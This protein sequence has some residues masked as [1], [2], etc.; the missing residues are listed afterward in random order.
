MVVPPPAPPAGSRR[1]REPGWDA[2]RIGFVLLVVLYHATHLG[3]VLHPDLAPRPVS[4][5][6]QIGASLLLVVSAYFACATLGRQPAGRYWWGRVARLLPAFL[7]AVPVAWI[8]LRFLA[9]DDWGGPRIRELAWNWLMLGNWDVVRFP[10]LD[11][12]F[13]TLPLQLMAFT[14]AAVLGTTRWASGARVRILTWALVLVPLLQW[15]L[16]AAPGELAPPPEWYRMIVDGFGFHRLHLFAAGIAV[17]MWSTRRLGTPHALALLALC[18][19]A[20]FVHG[21][22]EGPDGVLR[23]DATA[24]AGVCA[25]IALV[26]VV[27]RLPRPGSWTPAP[28][29][30]ALQWLAGISYGVYLMHQTVGY[31]LMRRLQDLGV[32]P[33]LQSAAMVTAAL[34]LGWAL[35]RTVEQP[36]HRALMGWWDRRAE[37]SRE[38]AHA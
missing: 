24:A 21:F 19:A 33:V 26:A 31:V 30:S 35:T 25:G 13:W 9:P 4:F 37:R 20:Q 11:P 22:A 5:D 1:R 36:A 28:F 8:T 15:P 10:W 32:G 29:A 12:A 7:V 34:L 6:H 27:S 2:L 23:V 17:W 18:G 3:P 38:P 16:R 14:A